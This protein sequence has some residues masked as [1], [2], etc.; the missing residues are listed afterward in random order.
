MSASHDRKNQ[1]IWE[2]IDVASYKQALQQCNRRIKKGEKGDYL[3][4]LKAH[5]LTLIPSGTNYD[6]ALSICRSI[7]QR[8]TPAVNDV[9]V[10]VFLQRIWSFLADVGA[11]GGR[12]ECR[13]EVSKVWEG[14]VKTVAKGDDETAAREWVLGCVRMGNWREMQKVRISNLGAYC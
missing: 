2:F 8:K 10:A 7:A 14:V 3:M 5:I 11:G 4:L 13:R 6:E 12:E 1:Q 9:A